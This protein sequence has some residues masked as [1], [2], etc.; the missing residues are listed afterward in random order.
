LESVVTAVTAA[1]L[2]LV[3][4]WTSDKYK[5]RAEN[6]ASIIVEESEAVQP[7]M[8]PYLVVAIAFRE[9]SFR[10]KVKGKHG[11]VGLMQVL[12]YGALTRTIIKDPAPMELRSNIR[13]GIGHLNYWQKKCG[14]KDIDTWISAYNIGRCV[15]TDY[16]K[17]IRSTY[18][19]VKPGG[20]KKVS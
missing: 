5:E 17:R 10:E 6:Y 7:K 16:A 12:P 2:S 3:P 1:I 14:N 20:C 18:C 9:S 8:D 19:K 4:H 15:K 13:I 11:E